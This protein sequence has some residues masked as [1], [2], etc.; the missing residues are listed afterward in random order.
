LIQIQRLLVLCP[1][2]IPER[3]GI[4]KKAEIKTDIPLR[5]LNKCK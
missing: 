5:G 2:H 3:V 1:G 4:N